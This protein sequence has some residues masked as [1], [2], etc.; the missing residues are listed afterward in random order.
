VSVAAIVLALAAA[1]LHA[2]WNVAVKGS[3]DPVLG[4]WSIISVAAVCS[5]PFLLVLRPAVRGIWPLLV[6]SVLVHV[7]NDV[8][9]AS[10]YER[11]DLSVAYPLARGSAPALIAVG[12]TLWLDETLAPAAI[13]GVVLVGVGV[14]V[15]AS[16]RW[17]PRGIAVAGMAAAAV[18][19]YTLVDSAA[20][21]QL[22][23]SPAFVVMMFP[24]HALGMTG[25]V[26]V[27][28]GPTRMRSYV[29]ANPS[30]IA[31]TGIAAPASYLLVLTA[32]QFA[33]VALVAALRE[34]SVIMAT[35]M[36][37]LLLREPVGWRRLLSV[38]LIA[39]GA[40]TLS[41]S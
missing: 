36:G 38:T 25:V 29:R 34:T 11:V 23:S 12:G 3:T 40:V 1:A 4:L 22:G 5:V 14:V 21:R 6:V 9:M 13:T 17:D 2:G 24:L 32:V 37:L 7:A 18:A 19:T 10:A 27:R 28:R 20:V 39:T 41:G 33:P 31:L 30:R 8:L 16:G 35:F 26:L 15:L